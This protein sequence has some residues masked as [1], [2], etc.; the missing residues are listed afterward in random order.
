MCDMKLHQIPSML[1]IMGV[2]LITALLVSPSISLAAE[3][4]V[5]TESG[6]HTF[7]VEIM[8]TAEERSKGLM[9]RKYLAPDAGMLFDFGDPLPVSMWMKNTYIPLDMLFISKDG[10]V[11]KIAENT[12][13]HSTEII[14]SNSQVKYVLEINGGLSAQFGFKP[15]NRVTLP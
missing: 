15:G 3:V 6:S 8:R 9:F 5:Q 12:T 14:S 11:H 10:V 13:P 4:T 7:S 2:L 1:M